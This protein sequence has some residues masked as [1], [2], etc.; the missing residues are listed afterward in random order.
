[1]ATRR[2]PAVARVL[3]RVTK[4]VREH[5]MFQPSDL[6]LVWVSGGPDS[7]CLLE[8]LIR[9]RRLFRIRL[10][11]FHMDHGL[12]PDSADDATYVRRLSARHRLPVHVARA[13]PGPERGASV[14]LWARFQRGEAAGRIL[15]EI[16]GTRYADGHTMDDQAESVLMGLVL[17]WGPEGMQGVAPV[18]GIL[19]R[20]L[21]D[22]SRAEVE[23]FCG[24]I[25]LRPRRDPTNDDTRFLRNALRLEAIPAIERATGRSVIPTFAQT[26]KLIE[27]ETR[28]LYELAAEHLDRVYRPR[29]DGFALAAGSLLDLPEALAARVVR[30]AFQRA[31]IGWDRPSIDRV[32]DLAAGRPGRRADLVA[33]STARRD[34]T[35]VIVERGVDVRR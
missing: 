3:E 2:P 26:G 5:D 31:G 32:L 24:A 6:V 14:E 7:V 21:L 11:V 12:R 27:R 30:R 13:A 22:V 20:P 10:A 16:G 34:R 29:R 28:A 1:V 35:S 9:L 19:V 4:T 17:G 23:A 15:G 25:G 33:G 18:N 8:S